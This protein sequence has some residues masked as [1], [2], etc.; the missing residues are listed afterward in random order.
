MMSKYSTAYCGLDRINVE[1][2]E[3]KFQIK[4]AI[5]INKKN[6]DM[7][8]HTAPSLLGHH[9]LISLCPWFYLVYMSVSVI[10]V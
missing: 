6:D 4:N 10:T 1:F 5:G 3:A 2:S 9:G 7:S 8:I